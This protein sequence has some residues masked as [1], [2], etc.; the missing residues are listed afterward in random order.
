MLQKMTGVD[1][2]GRTVV[3]GEAG[4]D[5]GDDVDTG[6]VLERVDVDEAG[7][8]SG[9]G[10]EVQAQSGHYSALTPG[11]SR[12]RATAWLSGSSTASSSTTRV[13]G[14]LRLSSARSPRSWCGAA[15]R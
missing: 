6:A 10:T 7:D 1:E 13:R 8:R 12:P 15:T 11:P 3:E 4:A 2:L 14:E 5:V 9:P